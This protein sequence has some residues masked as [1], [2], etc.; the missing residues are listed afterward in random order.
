MALDT[1]VRKEKVTK[2]IITASYNDYGPNADEEVFRTAEKERNLGHRFINHLI[3]RNRQELSDNLKFNYLLDGIPIVAYVMMNLFRSD[4]E[5]IVIVGNSDTEKIFN[6]FVDLYTVN[7]EHEKFRFAHEGDDWDF[8]NSIRKGMS[9]LELE[10]GELTLL[11][12]G[13]VPFVFYLKPVLEHEKIGHYD[14]ILN[15]NTK[16]RVGRYFPRNYHLRIKHHGK[17]YDVKEPNLFL[18]DFHKVKP[19]K[20][21]FLFGG[22]KTYAEFDE[23]NIAREVGRKKV[24][25]Y[26]F[27]KSF[28]SP[29]ILPILIGKLARLG[30]KYASRDKTPLTFPLNEA[31]RIASFLLEANIETDISNKDPGTLEDIDSLED[32]S[33]L[34]SMLQIDNPSEIYPPYR[35]LA[36]FRDEA[37]PVLVKEI[38]LYENFPEFINLRFEKFGLI[39]PRDGSKYTHPYYL[40]GKPFLERAPYNENEVLNIQFQKGFVRRMVHHNIRFHK[41]YVRKL[42]NRQ[43][44]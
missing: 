29:T 38:P 44:S 21:A 27:L 32:W 20:L 25:Q 24:I 33:Y 39:M 3:Y 40:G 5:E 41:R 43:T 9:A 34:N 14:G 10:R 4:L 15:G 35:E 17:T 26:L 37:M 28:N 11:I 7:Q 12:S 23:N 6:A 1:I 30:V 16:Q 36:R 2:A 42:R 13:D 19:E 8:E 31:K 18:F 22:R